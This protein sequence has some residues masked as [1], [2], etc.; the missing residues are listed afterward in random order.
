MSQRTQIIIWVGV[1]C[2]ALLSILVVRLLS[3]FGQFTTLEPRFAGSCQ[4]LGGVT[5]AEDIVIDRARNVAYLSAMDRRARQAGEDIRGEIFQLDLD[6]VAA[7]FKPLTGGIPADFRPKG[8]DLFTDPVSGEQQI[9][10]VSLP[11]EGDNRVEIFDILTDEGRVS[12]RHAKSVRDPLI[13]TPNDVGAAALNAF[14]VSNDQKAAAHGW[15]SFFENIFRADST[16]LVYFDGEVARV[17]AEELT[18]P[19]GVAVDPI[20]NTVYVAETLDFRMRVYDR[21]PETGALTLRPDTEGR[22]YLGTAPDNIDLNPDG[23]LWVAAHPK[24]LR[25]FNYARSPEALAPSQ[26]VLVTPNPDGP[27]G[28]VDQ[29]YLN[30]GEEIAGATVAAAHNGQ[31]LVGSIFD[32]HILLCDLPEIPGEFAREKAAGS[33]M[34][35]EGEPLPRR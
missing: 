20:D 10:A 8:I 18:F 5:G 25:F 27:G 28:M 24:S 1:G 32:D 26:V 11:A 19:N 4:R 29:V 30:K 22:V 33:K 2:L 16:D 12:L 31:M 17:V 21:N 34:R 23:S 14:Y 3:Q 6:N 9:F 7:G 13:R 35:A 15:G